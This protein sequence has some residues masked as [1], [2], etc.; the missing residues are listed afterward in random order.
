MTP[1]ET[2]RRLGIVQEGDPILRE[3]ARRYDLPAE[4]EDARRVVAQLSST[5]SRVEAAH[6]FGRGVGIAAP[7]IG[8]G[9]AATLVSL[10]LRQVR[11]LGHGWL[12]TSTEHGGE[13]DPPRGGR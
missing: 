5:I 1:S 10:F 9:G 4:A 12:A 3:V 6:V 7:Q 2:M 13:Q 8:I 11:A